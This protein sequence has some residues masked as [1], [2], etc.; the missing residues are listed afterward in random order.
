MLRG[1]DNMPK[2]KRIRAR[3]HLPNTEDNA[4]SKEAVRKFMATRSPLKKHN[5]KPISGFNQGV[6][7]G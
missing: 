6:R 5:R 4:R 7:N 2:G 1:E 3:E